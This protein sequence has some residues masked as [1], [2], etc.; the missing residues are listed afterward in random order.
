VTAATERHELAAILAEPVPANMGVVPPDPGFLELLR[1]SA[2]ESGA[3]LIFDEV[4]SGFRVARGGAQTLF[5]V[6]PDLT[7]MGKV[8]STWCPI[9]RSW[10]RFSVAGCLPRRSEGQRC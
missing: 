2:D 5:D 8:C 10:A 1:R 9:S 4:I 3:L 7:I 6:V